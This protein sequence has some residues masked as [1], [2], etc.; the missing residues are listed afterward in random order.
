MS[1]CGLQRPRDNQFFSWEGKTR[2][3]PAGFK[4]V[5]PGSTLAEIWDLWWLGDLSPESPV[6]P[7]RQIL[8]NNRADVLEAYE[9]RGERKATASKTIC[10][11]EQVIKFFLDE[12]KEIEN[13]ELSRAL[14]VLNS[15]N[16][17]DDLEEMRTSAAKAW[18][19]LWVPLDAKLSNVIPQRTR[20]ELPPS[21]SRH[22]KRRK[23]DV[24]ALG[25]RAIYDR[26][27]QLKR[28]Q[29]IP[30]E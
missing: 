15:G 22:V 2:L 26:I 12:C 18:N 29:R 21:G 10:E 17:L 27:T 20:K 28:Q 13:P 16:P 7:F 4:L 24:K 6:R 23:H 25:L 1:E 14:Q 9:L 5:R 3:V 30:V 19:I 11:I 8:K